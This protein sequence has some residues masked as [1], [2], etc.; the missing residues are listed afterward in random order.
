MKKDEFNS[1]VNLLSEPCI[2]ETTY[3]F[4]L[5]AKDILKKTGGG[6][7]LELG[8]N[9]GSSCLSFLEAGF[10]SVHSVDIRSHSA[11]NESL[12]TLSSRHD[13]KFKYYS[14]DHNS[15]IENK[16]L[17]EDEYD[18]VFIDGDHRLDPIRRDVNTALRFKPKY[19]LFD[20]YN[21]P[22]HMGD[23]KK[24]IEEFN[25][26]VFEVYNSDC[27]QVLIKL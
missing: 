16:D 24:I 11:V 10:E 13:A 2:G 22:A 21:H 3:E 7:I 1:L 20:D 26:E 5:S 4:F 15:I 17:F 14:L 6:K 18:L 25:F 9:R 23:V 27:G 19:I 12:N 8:F